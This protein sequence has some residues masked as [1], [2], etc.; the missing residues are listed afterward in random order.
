[1]SEGATGR[2]SGGWARLRWI[3]AGLVGGLLA[4]GA[5]VWAVSSDDMGGRHRFMH[6][7]H[8]GGAVDPEAAREHV[9]MGVRWVMGYVAGTPE[10]E[11]KVQA[12][13]QDALADLLPL[14]EQHN[15][16]RKALHDALSGA[17]IDREALEQA[18]R[19]EIKL[20]DQASARLAQAV[21]DAADTLTPEQRAQLAEAAARFHRH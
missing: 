9:K 1:M 13:A 6:R 10:Q 7:L 4:G 5:S 17:S 8:G 3:G 11:Q 15:A 21:A 2:R 20:A 12:I 16:N 18:R 14:R 19:A